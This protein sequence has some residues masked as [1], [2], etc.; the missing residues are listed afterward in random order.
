MIRPVQDPGISNRKKFFRK[1]PQQV[2]RH[3]RAKAAPLSREALA[4]ER[5]IRRTFSSDRT[6]PGRA[7]LRLRGS[8]AGVRQT[9]P[10]HFTSDLVIPGRAEGTRS[11]K[12]GKFW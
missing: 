3:P 9:R 12:E 4:A 7:S 10:S 5:R 8:I 6:T 1:S 2:I 11:G